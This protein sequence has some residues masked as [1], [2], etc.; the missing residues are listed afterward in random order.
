MENLEYCESYIDNFLEDSVDPQSSAIFYQKWG[1]K[2]MK[3]KLENKLYGK[4][5]AQVAR[6]MYV[7]L[8]YLNENRYEKK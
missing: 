8:N 4:N 6:L 2:I 7:D 1:D 3:Y 5:M